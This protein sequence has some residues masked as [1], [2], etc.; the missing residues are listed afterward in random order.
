MTVATTRSHLGEDAAATYLQYKS[1]ATRARHAT[2][3]RPGDTRCRVL[4]RQHNRRAH[5]SCRV[6]ALLKGSDCLG[7]SCEIQANG[8]SDPYDKFSLLEVRVATFRKMTPL[9]RC[10]AP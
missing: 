3:R 2:R 5:R 1:Q 6:A 9:L 4:R 8:S 10:V 7:L